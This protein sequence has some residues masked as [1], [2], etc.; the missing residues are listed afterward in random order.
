MRVA[1]MLKIIEITKINLWYHVL[2]RWLPFSIKGQYRPDYL[3]E[4]AVKMS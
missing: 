3:H 1:N 2:T 4:H